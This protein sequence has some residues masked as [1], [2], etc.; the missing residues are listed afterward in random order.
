MIIHL[1]RSHSSK[2]FIVRASIS[3]CSIS[4]LQLLCTSYYMLV[5]TGTLT[6]LSSPIYLFSLQAYYP[7]SLEFMPS[8]PFA[9]LLICLGKLKQ[10][11]GRFF[12]HPFPCCNMCVDSHPHLQRIW[13]ATCD[14]RLGYRVQSFAP[15]ERVSS[16]ITSSFAFTLFLP[17][18]LSQTYR[19]DVTSLFLKE[20]AQ[21]GKELCG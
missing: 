20:S 14:S 1:H 19:H 15:T 21:A 11:R 4:L 9:S 8:L 6:L 17:W 2:L 13:K 3:L 18:I 16:R 7:S 10:P 12:Q 5:V